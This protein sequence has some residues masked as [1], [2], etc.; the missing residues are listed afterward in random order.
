MASTAQPIPELLAEPLVRG[1][2]A[3][4]W[5][6]TLGNI[7]RQRSA[8]I[9]LALLAILFMTALLADVIE[10]HP[11]KTGLLGVEPGIERRVVLRHGLGNAMLPVVTVIG[12]QLGGLLS[13]AVLTETV[14]NLG[15]IG[16][17]IYEAVLG[18]DYQIIQGF[19]VLVAIVY[20][21][22]NLMVDLSYAKLDPRVRLA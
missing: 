22:V 14:F 12:L 3:S 21:I 9:G 11:H 17:A 10:T 19:T 18:R 15:G 16:R 20:I 6:D 8:V 5:R 4:L 2:Q 1:R 7:L 13:G